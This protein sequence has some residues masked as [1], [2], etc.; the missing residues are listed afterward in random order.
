MELMK[1]IRFAFYTEI[2]TVKR[3]KRKW[4][5]IL[6]TRISQEIQEYLNIKCGDRIA[7]THDF[8]NE[9]ILYLQ[10]AK[11]ITHQKG[12]V[13]RCDRGTMT[14]KQHA[15]K[16]TKPALVVR[17]NWDN[18]RAIPKW[19]KT[20]SPARYVLLDN[21]IILVDLGIK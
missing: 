17:K 19:A 15:A 20:A 8:G 3:T 16:N 5:Y 4:Q 21:N 9:F 18:P 2:N 11:N 6:T 10:N 13:T 14:P 12:H 7:I 1:G